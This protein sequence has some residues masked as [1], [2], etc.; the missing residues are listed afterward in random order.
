MVTQGRRSGYLINKRHQLR[1]IVSYVG[2]SIL[3]LAA[4]TL[5]V[6]HDVTQQIESYIKQPQL[7]ISSTGD[8][9]LPVVLSVSAQVTALYLILVALMTVYYL[10][11]TRRLVQSVAE[12]T[13]RFS[14]GELGFMFSVEDPPDFRDMESA[15]NEMLVVN[16][17]RVLSMRAVTEELDSELDAISKMSPD[18][19]AK[20][21]RLRSVSAGLDRLKGVLSGYR[22]G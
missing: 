19:M 16:R 10:H 13:S 22:L 4:S 9:I 5:M 2:I 11:R 6:L 3:A 15:F 18:D 7:E 21:G 1:Y 12:G 20:E 17:G 8:I 14:R